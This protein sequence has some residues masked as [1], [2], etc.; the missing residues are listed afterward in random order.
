MAD[1]KEITRVTRK[2]M[3]NRA[4]RHVSATW[5][6]AVPA[7]TRKEMTV[8][9]RLNREVKKPFDDAPKKRGAIPHSEFLPFLT[10]RSVFK[11]QN[12]CR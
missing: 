2:I 10:E 3:K 6:G 5:N 8:S 1:N 9:A 4:K 11:F 7:K 12:H